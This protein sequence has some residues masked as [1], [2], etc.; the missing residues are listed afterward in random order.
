MVDPPRQKPRKDQPRMR[1][2]D[3]PGG[4]DPVCLWPSSTQGH[5]VIE[6]DV[7]RRRR[8][9]STPASGPSPGPPDREARGARRSFGSGALRATTDY[10]D[11][12]RR[13][14]RARHCAF[15][16]DATWGGLRLDG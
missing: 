11:P 2:A 14:D 7:N 16:D 9:P 1:I 4:Q 3:R 12:R 6:V 13:R 15:V 5:E 8:E 10:A